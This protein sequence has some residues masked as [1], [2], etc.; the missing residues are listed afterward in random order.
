[1]DFRYVKKEFIDHSLIE[2]I[3]NS[4]KYK[5]TPYNGNADDLLETGFYSITGSDLTDKGFPVNLSN[6]EGLVEVYKTELNFVTQK[7]YFGNTFGS[8]YFVRGRVL[9]LYGEIGLKY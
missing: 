4:L 8:N 1:M 6:V 5:I 9:I 3:Q 7:F 2:D